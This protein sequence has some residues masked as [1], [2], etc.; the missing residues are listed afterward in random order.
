M[1][2]LLLVVLIGA[3]LSYFF[4]VEAREF[5]VVKGSNISFKVPKDF[6]EEKWVGDEDSGSVTIK[7]EIGHEAG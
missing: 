1:R 2:I 5:R 6:P 3:M 4:S 7:R